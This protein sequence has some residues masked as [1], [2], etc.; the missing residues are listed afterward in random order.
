M[1]EFKWV[2]ISTNQSSSFL[3]VNDDDQRPVSPP[4]PRLISP[5]PASQLYINYE[6]A[7]AVTT[8]RLTPAQPRL[9][10]TK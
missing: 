4:P 1:C 3:Q 5:A 6:K 9:T 10:G 7:K 8:A 2:D